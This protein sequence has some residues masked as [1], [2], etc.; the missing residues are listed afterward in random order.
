M[1]R[2]HCRKARIAKLSPAN[3]QLDPD[4]SVGNEIEQKLKVSM[5]HSERN[6]KAAHMIE[7]NRDAAGFDL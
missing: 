1:K 6:I 3:R 5:L 4:L 7:H 2:A